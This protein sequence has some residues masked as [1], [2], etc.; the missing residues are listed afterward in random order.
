MSPLQP[1][2]SRR[3][4]SHAPND[5]LQRP[6]SRS[7]LPPPLT[8]P[9]FQAVHTVPQ[10]QV[11]STTA[12][13]AKHTPLPSRPY[14]PPRV[15]PI[16]PPRESPRLPSRL[17]TSARIRVLPLGLGPGH[18]SPPLL[19]PARTASVSGRVKGIKQG[20]WGGNGGHVRDV[21]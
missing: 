14:A 16:G 19:H 8:P 1:P 15:K 17:P 6:C 3:I 4:R 21:L 20:G 12:E 7:C 13:M 10:C 9:L 5:P 11:S 18:G 2:L